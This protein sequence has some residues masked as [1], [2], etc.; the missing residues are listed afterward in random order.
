MGSLGSRLVVGEG[1]WRPLG[2][3]AGQ[4]SALEMGETENWGGNAEMSKWG[5]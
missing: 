2:G 5:K 3:G 4:W 1:R